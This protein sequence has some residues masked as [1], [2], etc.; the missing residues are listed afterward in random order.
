MTTTQACARRLQCVA[1][2]LILLVSGVAGCGSSDSGPVPAPALPPAAVAPPDTG[3]APAP[4]FAPLDLTSL[5]LS[6]DPG[7]LELLYAR[8]PT[9]DEQLNADVRIGEDGEPMPVRIRFRGNSA[10]FLP[11]KSFDIRF[12]EGQEL[13]FGSSRMNANAM[14]TDP[15]MMREHLAWGMWAALARPASRTR[16]LDI[17]INGVYE[18]LYIHIER[19]DADLLRSVGL[20]PA[21]TLV[22]DEFRQFAGSIIEGHQVTTF[23]AF[24]FPLSNIDS[25][26]TQEQFLSRTFDSRGSPRW[27]KLAE[28]ILWVEQSAPGTAFADGFRAR[29]DEDVFLDWLAIHFMIGDIDSFADDYWLY[30]D[31][32]SETA[33]WIVLPWDKDLSFGSH[34]RP[35]TGVANDYFAYDHP[36][37]ADWPNALVSLVLDTPDLRESLLGRMRALST[38]TFTSEYFSGRIGNAWSVIGASVVRQPG[39][40]AFVLH[41]RN[42]HSTQGVAELHM[43]AIQ[44]FVTLRWTYLGISD[45][46]LSAQPR[47][48]ARTLDNAQ[49]GDVYDF[50]D[51]AGW[52]IASLRVLTSPA[53]PGSLEISVQPEPAQQGINQLWTLRGDVPPFF[54]LLTLYYRNE[55]PDAF[56]GQNWYTEGGEAVGRQGDLVLAERFGL[57]PV[58]SVY[59]RANPFSNKVEG[60]VY[61]DP[62]MAQDFVLTFE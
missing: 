45:T 33:K 16:Y 60:L 55:V 50:A 42:H 2:I 40:D 31:H 15:A 36:I 28:L 22:R 7:D 48:A 25:A 24:N 27:D 10:R 12:A 18:G 43:E 35:G 20:N 44:D 23:S 13:L 26:A 59:S 19:V 47:S 56:S 51:V 38:S 37:G 62:S 53:G 21:G 49:P 41:P 9:S 61:V 11:K 14:Y 46:P 32:T 1:A 4:R 54:A 17:W 5:H 3:P 8:S 39:S 29:F 34:F 30:L 6:I 58:P 52:T 57:T